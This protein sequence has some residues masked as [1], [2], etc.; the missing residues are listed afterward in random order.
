MELQ[1]RKNLLV[2]WLSELQNVEILE[3][4]ESLMAFD[5]QE[6]EG[7][8]WDNLSPE[9]QNGLDEAIAGLDRGE[10]FT[11]EEV[12]SRIMNKFGI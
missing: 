9:E 12:R 7:K 2:E 1:E 5:Q 4:L 8:F 6:N 11:W 10:H 3:V